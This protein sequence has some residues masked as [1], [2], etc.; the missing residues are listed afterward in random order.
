MESQKE[1]IVFFLKDVDWLLHQYSFINR[2]GINF[3]AASYHFDF[4]N[5]DSINFGSI[6]AD[7]P[8]DK[9]YSLLKSK[10]NRYTKR[11]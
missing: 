4:E 3:Y 7:M 9:L 10:H 5:H 6:H 2:L 1:T 11:R 8:V